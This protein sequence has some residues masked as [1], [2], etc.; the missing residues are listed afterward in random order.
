MRIIDIKNAHENEVVLCR[1]CVCVCVSLTDAKKIEGNGASSFRRPTTSKAAG[2]RKKPLHHSH[3]HHHI[4]LSD[5]VAGLG[6]SWHTKASTFHKN[7][8]NM[9]NFLLVIN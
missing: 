9:C 3:H 5:Q 4:S 6:K 8:H 2:G 1:K 7:K